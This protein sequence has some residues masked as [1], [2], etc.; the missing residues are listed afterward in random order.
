M[1]INFFSDIA[2]IATVKCVSV[3]KKRKSKVK[4]CRYKIILI[5]SQNFA[6]K[7]NH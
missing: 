5:L 3:S 2:T 7:K 1:D 4:T 6:L